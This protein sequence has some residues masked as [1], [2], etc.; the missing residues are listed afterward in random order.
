[1]GNEHPSF[2]KPLVKVNN[3]KIHTQ[4]IQWKMRL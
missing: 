1:M 2:F 3:I 4:D